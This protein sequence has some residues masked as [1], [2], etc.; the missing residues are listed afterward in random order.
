MKFRE[1]INKAK[2]RNGDILWNGKKGRKAIFDFLPVNE[3]ADHSEYWK[4]FTHYAKIDFRDHSPDVT[5]GINDLL[6][7][8]YSL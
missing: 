2:G 8:P 3:S 5:F 4:Q 7:I 6:W 1:A